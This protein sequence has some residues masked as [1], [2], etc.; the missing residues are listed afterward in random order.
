LADLF[1]VTLGFREH[2]YAAAAA[3]DLSKFYQCVE[4]DLT[5]Q[6]LKRVV[7][8]KG[9]TDFQHTIYITTSVN[10]GDRP[11]G[12][13]AITAVRKTAQLS[14]KLSPLRR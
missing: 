10:Y 8:R 4:A 7:L 11:T 14:E 9:Q 6:H 3:K 13:I 1:A 5:A 12:C 2:K